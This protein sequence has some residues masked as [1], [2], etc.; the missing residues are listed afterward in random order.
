MKNLAIAFVAALLACIGISLALTAL[1]VGKDVAG[2]SATAL[3]GTIPFVRD[4]LDH[5]A[6]KRPGHSRHTILTIGSYA[7][8]ARRLLLYGILLQYG[9]MQFSSVLAGVAIQ[10]LDSSQQKNLAS[11]T[12][13]SV[14][15]NIPGMFLIGRWVG[16]RAAASGVITVLGIAVFARLLGTIVDLVFLPFFSDSLAGDVLGELS[17]FVTAAAQIGSG[18]ILFSAAGLLGYWRGTHQRLG[19]YIGYLLRNVSDET[20]KAIVDLAF[21]EAERERLQLTGDARIAPTH[22]MSIP[23]PTPG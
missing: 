14:L 23:A 17:N 7:L 16:R 21:E 11:I 10:V 19:S 5:L 2:A 1:G 3:F 20:R 18:V 15:I 4:S 9:I 22:G 6:N 13:F 12:I 8:P